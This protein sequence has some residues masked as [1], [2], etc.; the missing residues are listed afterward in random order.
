MS[1]TLAP[2]RAPCGC[3]CGRTIGARELC[4]ARGGNVYRLGHT[5]PRR[6]TASCGAPARRAAAP[7]EHPPRFARAADPRRPGGRPR[8]VVDERDLGVRTPVC[9]RCELPLLFCEC[10]G[11]A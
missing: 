7:A 9:D 2:V 3:G 4:M 6:D 8:E 11:A 5:P 10:R 1:A